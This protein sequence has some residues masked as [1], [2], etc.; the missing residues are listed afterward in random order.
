MVAS[1][2]PYEFKSV[3]VDGKKARNSQAFLAAHRSD[4]MISNFRCR[5]SASRQALV[6]A[7]LRAGVVSRHT[8][9]LREI[10]KQI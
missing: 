5:R 10:S 6:N 2:S 7:E 1:V 3:V 9:V 4:P 8:E